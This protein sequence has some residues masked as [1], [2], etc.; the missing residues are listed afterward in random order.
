MSFFSNKDLNFLNTHYGL[1][2]MGWEMCSMFTLAYLYKQGLSL[3]LAFTVYAGMLF[4][5]TLTRPIA[6]WCCLKK[7]VHFTL[8]VGTAVFACRYPAMLP[9]KGLT[10]AI[11]PFM[12]V[13]GLADVMYW[14][15]YHNYFASIGDAEDRGSSVGIRDAIATVVAV[16]GPV[17]G[18]LLLAVNAFYAFMMPFV[19]TLVAILPLL[20]TPSLPVPPK[21]TPEEKKHIDTFGF[22]VFI[23]DGLF[24]QA[25][26]IWPLIVFMILSENYGN[27]GFILA[28]AA[29]FRALGSMLF[30]KMIDK[31]KG[32]LICY[33]GYGMH[34]V[35]LTIRG[36][37]AYT[38]PV[39]IACDFFAAIAYCFSMTG[40]MTAVYN[41]TK[42]AKHPLYF[43]Y[44]TE[45]GW[46]VGAVSAMLM[47][48]GLTAVGI[49]LRWGLIIS[50][51]GAALKIVVLDRYY[52]NEKKQA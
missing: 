21:P 17:F 51:A 20:K 46:D 41:A 27:F 49:N 47:C 4:V 33:I 7:G 16:I 36:I 48:A 39:I 44:Y 45:L 28:L 32:A 31:G 12:L 3:P 25:G 2:A 10:W 34:I 14:V 15:P 22:V 40:L 23:G 18:G 38:V 42:R 35:I 30:G 13:S 1:R 19:L 6:M 8:M 43:T 50:I 9:I 11:V 52:R 24:Y 26:A 5:R 29:F 37:F